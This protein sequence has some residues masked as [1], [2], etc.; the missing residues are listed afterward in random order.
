MTAS[1]IFTILALYFNLE[2]DVE[3]NWGSGEVVRTRFRDYIP[4]D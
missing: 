4:V 2:K 3:E 1:G